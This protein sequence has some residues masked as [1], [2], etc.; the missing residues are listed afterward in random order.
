MSEF[1]DRVVMVTGASGN[2]GSAVVAAFAAAGASL[3]VPDR[4]PDR[5]AKL[6]PELAGSDKHF[7]ASSTDITDEDSVVGLVNESLSRLGKID[8]LVN[9]AGGYKAG[10]PPHETSLETWDFML[11]LNARATYLVSQTVVPSMIE[12][13]RGRI[14]NTAAR[15]ALSAGANEVAYAASKSAVARMT[16][17]F[18]AAYKSHGINVN[19][20]MPGTID[21]PQNRESMPKADT[22]R[23]VTP[24]AIAEVV[25]F[26]ASDAAAPV[27][28]A[29]LPV[30]GLS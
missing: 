27:H 9:T 4:S 11:N 10:S 5:A 12:R 19:A 29:L 16:E 13:Q 25:K 3:I 20:V 15:S 23:W 17:S 8:V 24:A 1:T 18:S 6:F 21:T 7:L 14:I 26:L 30:Y 2:L 22:S 28:G